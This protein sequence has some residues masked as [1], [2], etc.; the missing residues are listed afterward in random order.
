MKRPYS[1]YDHLPT[2][3]DSVEGVRELDRLIIARMG[4]NGY[5]LMR[6]AGEA[7]FELITRQWPD[8]KHLCILSGAGNNGGDGWVV[9]GLAL[10]AGL[11]VTLLTLGDLVKQSPS[12]TDARH[13]AESAGVIA[14]AFDGVLPDDAD[15]LVDGLLGTGLNSVVQGDYA[16]AIAAVNAH[17]APVL[18]LD[19][20]SGLNASSGTIQGSAVQ[21]DQTITF[22]GVKPGLLTCDGPDHCGSLHYAALDLTDTER[23]AV[24]AFAERVSWH[25]LNCSGP[26]LPT[27][28]GN[29]NKGHHG[30]ALLLGGDQGFG[31]AI[32][33]AVDA[34]CRSGAGLTSCVTRPVNVPVVLGRRPECMAVGV[35]SGLEVQPLLQRATVI[36]CGPGLGTSSWAELLFQQVLQSD[37]PAVLDADAL[38]IIAS[39]G[40]QTEFPERDVVLTPHPGE[41]ARLLGKTV[42]DIQSDR[43]GAAREIASRYQAVVVLK[44]Q[45]SV[46]ASPEGRVSVCTDGNPGMGTGGMGD[47]L[48][49]VVT[50]LLAQGLSAWEAAVRGAC[51]HSAAADLA[52]AEDAGVRGLLATDLMPYIRRLVN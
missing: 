23:N 50:A 3:I 38:N 26:L 31:G 47:V 37:H 19:V 21:A 39:P 33:M 5:A 14:S 24:S 18:A 8:A 17:P 10:E 34:C 1:S 44:G 9:A 12:A 45:G 4:D 6:K 51:I 49:G 48:T 7:A 41:A 35:E 16:D 27:R 43:Y 2:T 42:P 36:G 46:I 40:W 30:H 32:A 29:S 15:L 52:V 28:R 11:R 22:I 20:P 13:M 25:S